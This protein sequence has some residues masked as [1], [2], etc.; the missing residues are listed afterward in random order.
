LHPCDREWERVCFRLCDGNK[1]LWLM[2]PEQDSPAAQSLIGA[3]VRV[4]GVVGRHEDEEHK[5][6]GA[7]LHV[8]TLKDIQ[9]E[10]PAVPVLLSSPP[11]LIGGLGA[12]DANE[13]FPGQVH[14]RGL[15]TWQ[16]PGLFTL[17]DDSGTIFVGIR[18]T[19]AIRTGSTVDAIGFPSRGQLGLELSDSVVSL[20][21]VQSKRAEIGPLQVTAADVV[22]RSLNGRRVQ[23]KARLIG[24]SANANEFVYQLEEG[25][26]RFNAVLLRSD[27][28]RDV[29]GLSRDSVVELTGVALIQSGSAE[30]P[31]A[32]LILVES[33]KDIVVR[34]S[35]GWL[36]LSRGLIILGLMAVCA[37]AYCAKAD[38][39]HSRSAR[40][41]GPPGD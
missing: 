8:E 18:K 12:S 6:L 25:A 41:R 16:S 37:S 24:Q 34:G 26:Q 19:V 40:K 36:T 32:L 20:A 13:R 14:L 23:L 33:P 17:H 21:A 9:V 15:V 30:W 38:G 1:V 29:V 35:I 28:T 7:Q 4:T 27:A 39:N 5:R 22:K 3:I 2:V 11:T 31:G 10:S